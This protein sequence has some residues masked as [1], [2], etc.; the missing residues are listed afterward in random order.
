M[1]SALLILLLV[2]FGWGRPLPQVIRLFGSVGSICY[3]VAAGLAFQRAPVYPAEA[4]GWRLIGWAALATVV[5]N[6]LLVLMPHSSLSETTQKTL[7]YLFS[8]LHQG[9]LVLGVLAWPWRELRTQRKI[10]HITGSLLF[11]GSLLLLLWSIGSWGVSLQASSLLNATLFTNSM[12]I[13]LL[14]GLVLYLVF[15]APRRI[16]RALGWLLV[17]VLAGAFLTGLIQALLTRGFTWLLPAGSLMVVAPLA[18]A[19]AAYA[20]TPV[21][22]THPLDPVFRRRWEFIPY[23]PFLTAGVLVLLRFY[24]NPQK[25]FFGILGMSALSALLV[26]R[27]WTLLR[28]VRRANLDLEA[29]VQART[30]ELQLH[31]AAAL[32]TE[33]L[34]TMALLGAGL[35][36]DLNNALTVIH[37]SVDLCELGTSSDD[38]VQ[39]QAFHRIRNATAG[40]A[41]LGQRLLGFGH[42]E[43]ETREVLD[44]QEVLRGFEPILRMA[45]PSRLKLELEPGLEPLCIEGTR[46][47]LEQALLNLVVNA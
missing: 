6:A 19:L 16:N 29:R 7:W 30:K 25:E 18:L 14:G 43:D 15:E 32:R 8:G 2:L 47:H 10:L 41:A 4:R 26:L 13:C 20:R 38:T 27:Q 3:L 33:R 1:A 42:R 37:Q 39:Q 45:L 12:R 36:H 34:N 31:Q 17:N 35:V 5:S 11:T 24:F 23:L 28:E 46:S 21:E 40:V 9:L 44:L 22:T